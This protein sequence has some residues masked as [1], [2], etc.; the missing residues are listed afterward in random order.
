MHAQVPTSEKLQLTSTSALFSLSPLALPSSV[1]FLRVS[2][3]AKRSP[4]YF[5]PS[6]EENLRREM[7]SVN[8][9]ALCPACAL[10]M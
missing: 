6:S 5:T 4:L 8:F 2:M 10:E 3:M 1:V 9:S 7:T